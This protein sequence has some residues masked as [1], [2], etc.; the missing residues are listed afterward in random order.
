MKFAICALA[1]SAVAAAAA[2]DEKPK[3][4]KPCTIR[5]PTSGAYYDLNSLNVVP[6]KD[7]KPAKGDVQAEGWQAKGYDFGANFTLNFCGPVATKLEDVEG[8]DKAAW[9]NVSAYYTQG[10]KTYSI[11]QQN[12]EPI[13]RGRKLVLNY[14]NGSP[15]DEHSKRSEARS[16]KKTRRKSTIISLLCDKDPP[17]PKAPKAVVAFIGASDDACTFFFEARSQAACA[18]IEASPQ[19]LGPGGVF[20]VIAMIALLVYFIGGCVYQRAVMHQRGWRQ[21]PNYSMWAGIGG[22]LKDI[23]II[24]TSSCARFIPRSRGYSQVSSGQ[25]GRVSLPDDE[26]R[27]IDQLDE[28]WDD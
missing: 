1:L 21:L 26:N 27:L 25:R 23:F 19:Q 6:V 20:G 17:A 22:F 28:E 16:D 14:T 13:F 4:V 9:Q 5:S 12:A 24:L 3:P 11:G 2:A 15:C 10:K 7:T 8:V 18:G